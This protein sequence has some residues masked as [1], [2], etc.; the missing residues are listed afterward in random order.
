[1][2]N[3]IPVLPLGISFKNWASQLLIDLPNSFI[4]NPPEINKWRDWASQL[5]TNDS[6][7]NVPVPSLEAYPGDEGWRQWAKDFISNLK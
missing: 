3:K 4:P 7:P 2:S 1:M 6:L 5:L